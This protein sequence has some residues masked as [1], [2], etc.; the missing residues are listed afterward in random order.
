MILGSGWWENL[1]LAIGPISGI[2]GKNR[3]APRT[4]SYLQGK[5]WSTH[6][7][8]TVPAARGQRIGDYMPAVILPLFIWVRHWWPLPTKIYVI[9]RREDMVKKNPIRVHIKTLYLHIWL[10]VDKRP[11]MHVHKPMHTSACVHNACVRD[12]LKIPTNF[13]EF[14]V[15]G[16]EIYDG[17]TGVESLPL[18]QSRLPPFNNAKLICWNSKQLMVIGPEAMMRRSWVSNN[19][20]CF[21]SS[22]C[23]FWLESF[24]K[25]ILNWPIPDHTQCIKWMQINI[26]PCKSR[27]QHW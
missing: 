4:S 27:H 24:G 26:N 17:I 16:M 13:T 14:Q 18:L 10:R 6:F 22:C 23:C 7:H 12:N 11:H 1:R 8:L 25:V 5:Q 15:Q 19:L 21:M 9:Y 2:G 20:S 3:C